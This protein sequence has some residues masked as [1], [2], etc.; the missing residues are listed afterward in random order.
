MDGVDEG[1]S[2]TARAGGGSGGGSGGCSGCGDPCADPSG[3]P[4]LSDFYDHEP[5]LEFDDS[6]LHTQHA[7]GENASTSLS[8]INSRHPVQD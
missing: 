4:S 7:E 3:H 6:D 1:R 8:E 2:A 5:N